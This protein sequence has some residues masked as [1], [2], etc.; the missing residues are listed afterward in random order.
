ME[1]LRLGPLAKVLLPERRVR[2]IA[3]HVQDLRLG[4]AG[5]AVEVARLGITRRPAIR[6]EVLDVEEVALHDPANRIAPVV[7]SANV[8]PFLADENVIALRVHLPLGVG[9]E[10]VEQATARS[11]LHASVRP[12]HPGRLQK[13]RCKVDEAHEVVDHATRT[14]NPLLPHDCQRQMVRHLIL[15]PLDARER[16][17]VVRRH[18]D[19]RVLKLPFLFQHGDHLPK[20][21]IEMLNLKCVVE[22]VIPRRL[23]VGPERRDLVDVADFLATELRTRPVFV[24]AMRFHASIPEAPR[25]ALGRSREKVLKVARVIAR[26][27]ARRRRLDFPFVEALPHELA[28]LPIDLARISRGPALGGQP[29]EVALLAQCLAIRFE[30]RREKRHVVRRFLELPGISSGQDAGPRRRTLGIRRVGPIEK[31]SLLRHPV[32]RWCC[33]PGRPIGPHVREGTVVRNGEQD[34]G[35]GLQNFSGRGTIRTEDRAAKNESKRDKEKR[36][37]GGHHQSG[38]RSTLPAQMQTKWSACISILLSWP[39]ES[40]LATYFARGF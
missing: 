26:A 27:D 19:Q 3:T 22:H 24:G 25:P 11:R 34:V 38:F 8:M 37:H 33:H 16:H 36:L 30:L 40:M 20:M 12:R 6:F 28:R 10:N 15:L 14:L 32:K 35:P 39:S 23:C 21:G 1:K 29:H 9:F 4:R 7:R 31:Q 13:R 5:V 2:L 18:H 17:A